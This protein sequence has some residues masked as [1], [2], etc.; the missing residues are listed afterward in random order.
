MAFSSSP[1]TGPATEITVTGA[2][3]APG[4]LLRTAC[5][6][7]PGRGADRDVW[8]TSTAMG[9][10]GQDMTGVVQDSDEAAQL[11][12]YSFVCVRH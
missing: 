7:P 12:K 1:R 9:K 5:M 6:G 2:R 3:A 4:H 11:T 8:D 10:Q